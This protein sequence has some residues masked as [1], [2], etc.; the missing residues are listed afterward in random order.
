MATGPKAGWG[1]RREG[2]GRPKETLSTLQ[3]RE[4]LDKAK[5]YAAKYKKTIDEILLDFIYEPGEKREKLQ[6]IKLWKERTSATISE[7]GDADQNLGP[8]IYLPGEKPD[9]A[10]VV[11]IK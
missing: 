8:G 1:G 3:V 11:P 9:P 5:E 10:K 6:A 7:G 2:A 4:M